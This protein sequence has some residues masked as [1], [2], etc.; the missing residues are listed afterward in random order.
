VHAL[1][2]TDR[3]EEVARMLGGAQITARTRDHAREMLESAA[4]APSRVPRPASNG[5]GN[6]RARSGR[7]KSA[8]GR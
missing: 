6:A 4:Q 5:A 8:R 3:I 1:A 2:G 7:A